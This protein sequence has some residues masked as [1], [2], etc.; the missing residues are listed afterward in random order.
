M[1]T[2]QTSSVHSEGADLVFDT[3]GAGQPILLIRG[4]GGYASGY[5]AFAKILA[6]RYSVIT[7]DRRCNARSSGDRTLPLDMSQQARDVLAVLHAAGQTRAMI[8]GNSSGGV[9]GLELSS[10][11]PESVSLLMVHEPP[12][13]N[14]LP[15]AEAWRAYNFDLIKTFEEQGPRPAM[16]RFAG[17]MVGIT[18]PP[19][20]GGLGTDED[21]AFLLGKELL[22]VAHHDVDLAAIR[23]AGVKTILMRGALSGDAYYART[24]PLWLKRLGAPVLRFREIISRLHSS[25]K[26]LAKPFS[27]RS[28]KHTRRPDRLTSTQSREDP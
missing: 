25:R 11:Y 8:F 17:T 13:I 16:M 9:V 10:R 24:A 14:V 20:P 4:A 7:F 19:P 21:R 6:E 2:K 5:E 26:R 28:T 3:R 15:D 1:T 27:R 18:A 12:L 22:R 23:N